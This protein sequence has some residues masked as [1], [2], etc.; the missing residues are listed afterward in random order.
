MLCFFQLI[1]LWKS[2]EKTNSFVR[3]KQTKKSFTHVFSKYWA[4]FGQNYRIPGGW[5]HFCPKW[6]NLKFIRTYVGIN[7]PNRINLPSPH[8]WWRFPFSLIHIFTA[9]SAMRA[10][11]FYSDGL[12][13]K[14]LKQNSSKINE[15]RWKHKQIQII[16]IYE[17][18]RYYNCPHQFW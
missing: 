9:R 6:V 17:I 11:L 8:P 13:S 3:Q 12:F 10:A 16:I 7:N 1:I 15:N 18:S 14:Y 4:A 5:K 2:K